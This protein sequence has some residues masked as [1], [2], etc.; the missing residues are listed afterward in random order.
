MS[1]S[2][3]LR[4][5]SG[6]V[7][8]SLLVTLNSYAAC[9]DL[10]GVYEASYTIAGQSYHVVSRV[11]QQGC[12]KMRADNKIT[13]PH[14]EQGYSREWIADGIFRRKDTASVESAVFTP[15]GLLTTEVRSPVPN[16]PT[17]APPYFSRRDLVSLD[18]RGNL[19]NSED[20]FDEQGHHLGGDRFVY[21]RT[22]RR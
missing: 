13:G 4:V 17:P 18:A 9:P 22:S 1:I 14:G 7:L 10:S 3:A 8:S 11:S 21:Q 6:I 20:R 16:D 15:A 12:Q 19:V 2:A 5:F